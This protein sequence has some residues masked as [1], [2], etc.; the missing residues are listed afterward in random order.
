MILSLSSYS[1]RYQSLQMDYFMAEHMFHLGEHPTWTL[2]KCV[3]CGVGISARWRS[4]KSQRL[5]VWFTLSIPSPMIL[6]V[7]S[8][9]ERFCVVRAWQRRI[10]WV[11]VWIKWVFI[12]RS[13]WENIFIGYRTT[14]DCFSFGTAFSFTVST[15]SDKQAGCQFSRRALPNFPSCFF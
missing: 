4:I 13:L 10:L 12:S 9:A 1:L 11:S 15:V 14:D 6:S 2:S 7:S 8:I 5:V 3:F